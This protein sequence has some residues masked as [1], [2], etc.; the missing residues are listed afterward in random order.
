MLA[1]T[2]GS[3]EWLRPSQRPSSLSSAVRR[4]Y[5]ARRCSASG[6]KGFREKTKFSRTSKAPANVYAWRRDGYC[7]LRI[8]AA[9]GFVAISSGQSSHPDWSRRPRP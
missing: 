9:K 4:A 6:G 1:A 7:D 5:W 3:R 2:Q 8:D